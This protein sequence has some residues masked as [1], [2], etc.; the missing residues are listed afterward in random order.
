MHVHHVAS[1]LDGGKHPMPRVCTTLQPFRA[2][3]LAV[4][5]QPWLQLTAADVM[6]KHGV[7]PGAAAL[8]ACKQAGMRSL[9]MLLMVS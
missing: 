3:L 6:V 8:V 2:K 5:S 4:L 7:R 9:T 1:R